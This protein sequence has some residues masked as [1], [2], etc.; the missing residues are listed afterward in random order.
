[1]SSVFISYSRQDYEF[2][3]RLIADLQA[4][5]IQVWIDQQGLQV[6][7]PSWERA[8]R[9]AIRATDAVVLIAS[10]DSGQSRYVRGELHIAE[11]YKHPVYPVWAAGEL[12]A[13]CVPLGLIEMQHTDA[14][15]SKYGKALLDLLTALRNLQSTDDDK[16]A[17]ESAPIDPNF[18]PRNPYKGLRAFTSNDTGDFF[19]RD[20][21][22]KELVE[23]V[24][25]ASKPS[26]SRFLAIVGPSGSGKSSVVMAGLLPKLQ[27]GAL[28][29]SKEWV[30]LDPVLPGS[31]PLESLA[32]ILADA[33]HMANSDVL[34]D[35]DASARG[36]HLLAR[37]LTKGRGDA[38]VVLLVDQFEELFTQTMDADKRDHFID[39]LVTA[40]QERDGQLLIILTLRADFYDRPMNYAPLGKLLEKHTKSVLPMSIEDLRDVIEKPAALPDVKLEFETGL[41][42]DLLFEVRGQTGA[43]PLLQFTL[44]QLAERRQGRKLTN[45]AYQDMGGVKGALAKHAESVY[46]SLPTDQHRELAR[47][48]FLRLIEPGATEQDTTRRRAAQSEL[49]TPDPKQTE[50]LREVSAAFVNARLLTTNVIA[51]LAVI[52]VSHEALIRE[53]EQLANWLNTAR[54]DVHLQQMISRDAREWLRIGKRVDDLYRGAKLQ[55]AVSWAERNIP[56]VEE[57][58]FINAARNNE[59]EI[60]LAANRQFLELEANSR[61]S[62]ELFQ[63]VDLEQVLD[64]IRI[65]AAKATSADG[66][67]V[68]LLKPLTDWKT[69][70]RPEIEQR[71][72]EYKHTDGLADIELEAIKLQGDV[73]LVGDYS[74][75]MWAAWPERANSAIAAAFLYGDEVVG[76]LHL[77]HTHHNHFD[78]R[79][80]SF[81]MMLA[82]KAS[83]GFGNAKRYHEQSERSNRLRQR[84]E[85]LNQ[86]FELG[87]MLQANTD[88]TTVIEAILYSIQ[89]SVGFDI[90]LFVLMDERSKILSRVVQ[91]GMPMDHFENSK[92]H[93]MTRD[94]LDTI[95]QTQYQISES[96][97]IPAEQHLA[98]SLASQ[99]TLSTEFLGKSFVNLNDDNR[100]WQSG[101]MLLV[102][103]LRADGNLLGVMRLDQP[104]NGLRPDRV[105]T[106]ILEI[107]AHQ[108]AAT[109]ENIRLYMESLNNLEQ[110]ARLSEMMETITGTLDIHEI[111]KAVAYGALRLV[112][113]TQMTVAMLPIE[114]SG[115]DLLNVVINAD[116]S[117]N[118]AIEHRQNLD[119][120]ALL[121]TLLESQD[122]LYFADDS[123]I[124]QYRDLTEWHKNGERTTLVVPLV[125]SGVTLGAMH[126]GSE[127]AQAFSFEEY[128]P[129]FKRMANLCAAAIQ[130][131]RLFHR[132][133]SLNQELNQRLQGYEAELSNLRER[134]EIQENTDM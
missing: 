78:D 54:T 58:E 126:L 20:G 8:I 133:N 61:V 19:G 31:Q 113:F 12:W 7:T 81:L 5:N 108:A 124:A 67:T 95:M 17:S 120:T 131:S 64:V 27:S 65:E 14:R 109:M 55:E 87:Q 49:I 73:V 132:I 52:E 30:Y 72:G 115:F 37:R 125:S 56:S 79:T 130:N 114:G 76:V 48:L 3:R 74:A 121:Q 50:L 46:Q 84:V 117:L 60:R 92:I 21:L 104:Q 57:L 70:D 118:I 127:L 111:V 134:L 11:M 96:Y 107:F 105:T 101:D 102:P 4:E 38:R 82:T 53:W 35:L 32:V 25:A 34:K 33:L 66:S 16:Q 86:I 22:V 106:E 69:P 94:E 122:A 6:G 75:S 1:V 39:L 77:Y 45:A 43:L 26:G 2:V 62:N 13:E 88:Q 9:D 36:L 128:R 10:T 41:V 110:E 59:L 47:S 99:E 23:A 97:F 112:P 129:L 90:G 29:G 18:I 51:G 80:I 83:L 93:T 103:L 119:S 100:A 89:Q 44:D 42:G 85:Q 63:T 116:S 68:I 15:G 40:A 98:L 28:P 24:G 123:A 91:V 71:L